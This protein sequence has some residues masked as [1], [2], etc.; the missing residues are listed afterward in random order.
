MR[1]QM[2]IFLPAL[3]LS[4]GSNPKNEKNKAIAR[5]LDNYLYSD[6]LA[7]AMPYGLSPNDSASFASDYIEKWIRNQLILN[8]A[9]QNLTDEEKNVDQQIQNYRTSLL[10]YTYEQSYVRQKLDTVV[11]E[12]EMETYLHDNPNNFLLRETMIKGSFIKVPST[13]PDIYRL[14]QWC[15]SEDPADEVNIEEYCFQYAEKYEHFNDGWVNLS[16]VLDLLP[17]TLYSPDTQVK[18]RRL[19]EMQ[20]ASAYYFLIIRDYALAGNISPFDL[21]RED[22]RS[23]ILNKRKISIINELESSI[24]NDGQNRGYFTIY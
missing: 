12:E 5:V 16:E 14:R 2:L 19:I 18:T 9:E 6:D 13:A 21:V 15:R 11:T 3:M 7:S 17:G 24:V 1:L 4:C 10:I 22:I 8:K 23:I 20:D